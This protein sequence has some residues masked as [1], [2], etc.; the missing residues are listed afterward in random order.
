VVLPSSWIIVAFWI[1]A[2]VSTVVAFAI[3]LISRVILALYIAIGPLLIGLALFPAT[4]SILERW[5]GSLVS[6]VILQITTIVLLY[7]VLAVEQQVT[8]Q[9]ALTAETDLIGRV[10][11]LLAGVIFFGLAGFVAFQLPAS[12]RHCPAVGSVANPSRASTMLK[13]H[14][15]YPVSDELRKQLVEICRVRLTSGRVRSLGASAKQ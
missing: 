10:E 6:C 1:V 5:I 2:I 11:V 14:A 9:I 4:R 13:H 3:W 7:I 8:G 12:R 15:S